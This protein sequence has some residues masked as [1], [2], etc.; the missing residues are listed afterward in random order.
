MD[1]FHHPSSA[2]PP[3][4]AGCVVGTAQGTFSLAVFLEAWSNPLSPRKCVSWR[5]S[6]GFFVASSF[7]LLAWGYPLSSSS[8]CSPKHLVHAFVL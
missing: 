7:L 1:D 6:S 2:C 5:K 3:T 8:L 4:R